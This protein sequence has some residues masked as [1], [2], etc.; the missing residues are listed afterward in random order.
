MGDYTGRHRPA[1]APPL[2]RRALLT[3]L[4]SG[5][6]LTAASA[7]AAPPAQAAPRPAVA[8]P[9][10]DPP[11]AAADIALGLGKKQM[12]QWTLERSLPVRTPGHAQWLAE[13]GLDGGSLWIGDSTFEV[14]R[15]P[16]QYAQ[17]LAARNPGIRIVYD[18]SSWSSTDGVTALTGAPTGGFAPFVPGDTSG[19]MSQVLNA[20]SW[21]AAGG[22]DQH[23]PLPGLRNYTMVLPA[24]AAY[25]PWGANDTGSSLTRGAVGIDVQPAAWVSPTGATQVLLAQDS[26]TVPDGR[27]TLLR[28]RFDGRVELRLALDGAG[29]QV[30]AA[31]TT[32]PVTS[33][34][35]E[36]S[37]CAVLFEFDLDASGRSLFTPYYR[38]GGHGNPWRPLGSPVQVRR[39]TGAWRGNPLVPWEVGGGGI[40]KGDF[41]EAIVRKVDRNGPDMLPRLPQQWTPSS[42][43]MKWTLR[44]GRTYWMTVLAWSGRGL[45]DFAERT[46]ITR[47]SGGTPVFTR[48]WNKRTPGAVNVVSPM[49]MI[50]QLPYLMSVLNSGHNEA[51]TG[52]LNEQLLRSVLSKVRSRAPGAE[53]CL[54]V[55]NATLRDDTS[56]VQANGSYVF[57][58]TYTVGSRRSHDWRI[59]QYSAL[60]RTLGCTVLDGRSDMVDY[61]RAG[62]N[63]NDLLQAGGEQ[64]HPNVPGAQLI[65]SALIN[66]TTATDFGTSGILP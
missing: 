40:F 48:A 43:N 12:P 11:T 19:T 65:A 35:P 54:L 18:K 7:L 33:V 47:G 2:S 10:V 1:G 34:V 14:T 22:V 46:D 28:I 17:Q 52:P 27:G 60:A 44:G 32:V 5:A 53:H 13:P 3:G 29:T 16:F 31:T 24:K 15:A 41:Y 21:A 20:D 58:Q 26:T 30:V 45:A 56:T 38:T 4:G 6:A 62:G 9:D 37:R 50:P 57:D 49:D 8:A 63:L 39:L 23:Q 42:A 59:A 36:G 55:Q 66:Q 51:T 25:T 64:V 61:A